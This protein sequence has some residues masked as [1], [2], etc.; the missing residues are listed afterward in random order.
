MVHIILIF[1]SF[2]AL[3]SSRKISTHSPFYANLVFLVNIL[4]TLAI[5]TAFVHSGQLGQ[6]ECCLGEV[7]VKKCLVVSE[8]KNHIFVGIVGGGDVGARTW[9]IETI[10]SPFQS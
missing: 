6:S 4:A 8:G 3:I 1:L 9:T 10:P 7:G 2:I 5:F